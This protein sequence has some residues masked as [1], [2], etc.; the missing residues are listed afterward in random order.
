MTVN[1][2]ELLENPEVLASISSIGNCGI[3]QKPITNEHPDEVRM[4]DGK[5]VHED[6]YF[7]FEIAWM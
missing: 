5:P 7:N 3:C 2:K 1:E 6:C 4:V